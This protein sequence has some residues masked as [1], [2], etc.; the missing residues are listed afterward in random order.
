MNNTEDQNRCQKNPFKFK[1]NFIK[2]SWNIML[3][4]DEV[5]RVHFCAMWW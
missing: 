2:E 4:V 1:D 5:L 3:Y